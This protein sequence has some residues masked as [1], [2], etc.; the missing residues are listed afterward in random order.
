MY[1]CGVGGSGEIKKGA[2]IPPWLLPEQNLGQFHFSEVSIN[3]A[4]SLLP[5]S[6]SNCSAG[7]QHSFFAALRNRS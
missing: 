4:F 5:D 3:P 1:V 7:I 6:Y 2:L